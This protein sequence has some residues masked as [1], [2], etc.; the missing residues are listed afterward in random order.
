MEP[1]EADTTET[2]EKLCSAALKLYS[3]AIR[4]SLCRY[5]SARKKSGR[6]KRENNFV[7]HLHAL[8]NRRRDRAVKR[9][10]RNATTRRTWG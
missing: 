4:C 9:S 5:P 2:A 8:E 6:R 7:F 1:K 3:T 10:T